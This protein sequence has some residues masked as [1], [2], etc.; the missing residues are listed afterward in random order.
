MRCLQ[1]YPM[2]GAFILDGNQIWESILLLQVLQSSCV[3]LSNDFYLKINKLNQHKC[4][5]IYKEKSNCQES[6]K[7]DYAKHGS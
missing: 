4:L 1:L 6:S 2:P 7:K 5:P 3:Y